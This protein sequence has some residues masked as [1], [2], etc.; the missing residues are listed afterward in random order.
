MNGELYKEAL[1][2]VEWGRCIII[3]SRG[4]RYSMQRGA[5]LDISH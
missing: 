3:F 1:I 5:K 4:N 2:C